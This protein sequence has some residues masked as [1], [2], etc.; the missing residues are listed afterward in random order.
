MPILVKKAN[1]KISKINKQVLHLEAG[2]VSVTRRVGRRAGGQVSAAA[3]RPPRP[4]AAAV[5]L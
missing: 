5:H 1:L 3:S 2:G 4:R